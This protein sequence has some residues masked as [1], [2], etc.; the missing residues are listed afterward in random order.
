MVFK[1]LPSR[2]PGTN[3][4]TAPPLPRGVPSCPAPGLLQRWGRLPPFRGPDPELLSPVFSGA[5]PYQ[6][7]A[8][9]PITRARSLTFSP[10]S[11]QCPAGLSARPLPGQSNQRP[12]LADLTPISL[13]SANPRAPCSCPPSQPWALKSAG[14]WA[15]GGP[16]TLTAWP[17]GDSAWPQRQPINMERGAAAE[18]SGP[19]IP[20][21]SS[22]LLSPSL[23]AA[24]HSPPPF[25]SFSLRHPSTSRALSSPRG[26][27]PAVRGAAAAAASSKLGGRKEERR[28]E[29]ELE[30]LPRGSR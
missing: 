16:S 30:R 28:K 11:S 29:G 10:P 23:R 18:R 4:D 12:T 3:P 22:P 19:N 5:L 14:E 1:V 17:I 7:L 13:P 15:Q 25:P 2:E 21:P 26:P 8:S 20:P 27:S 9:Q 6:R 24:V